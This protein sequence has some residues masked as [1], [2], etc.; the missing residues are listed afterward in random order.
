MVLNSR[1]AVAL[2]IEPD[3]TEL[4]TTIFLMIDHA[5]GLPL[6]FVDVGQD[7]VRTLIHGLL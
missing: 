5:R 3:S 4:S 7:A 1:V 6:T 2:S